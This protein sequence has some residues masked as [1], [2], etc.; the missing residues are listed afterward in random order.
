LFLLF[1][2]G[3]F[4]LPVGN[5]SEGRLEVRVVKENILKDLPI[6]MLWP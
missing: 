5:K 1:S 2:Q 6:G 3:G 4:I